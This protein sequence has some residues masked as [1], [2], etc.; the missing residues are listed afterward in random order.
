VAANNAQ[1]QKVIAALKELGIA[2]KDIQTT[3]FS[4][5]PSQNYSPDGQP[6]ET[7]YVVDN[8]V[9]VTIR[10][11]SKLG[12]MLDK[13][14]AAGVNTVNSIQ[15]DVADK[16]EALKKAR[17]EAVKD[18]QDQAKQLADAAGLKLGDVHSVG[19]SE[20]AMPVYDFGKGGGGGAAE[21]ATTVPIQPGQLTITASVNMSYDIK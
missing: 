8:T 7:K 5:W 15:F 20:S 2:D 17:A 14:I 10:D 11:L 12:D 9:Y 19:F 21:A 13:V 1:T 18:A 16:A 4:I 3:N 6:L